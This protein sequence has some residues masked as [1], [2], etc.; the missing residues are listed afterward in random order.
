MKIGVVT[1]CKS[2][3]YGAMLQAR[4]LN[5]LLSSWGHEIVF[6]WH[7]R[8][9]AERF[10][11]WRCFTIRSAHNYLK[12]LKLRLSRW[13]SDYIS[14][15]ADALRMSERCDTEDQLAAA[16]KDCDMVI[17]GSDQIWNPRWV[18]PKYVKTVFLAFAPKG[19]RKISY[20][21]SFSEPKWD[22][23][24]RRSAGNL[25][26]Q[27]DAISVREAS[28]VGIVKDLC[29]RIACVVADPTFL[30]DVAYYDRLIANKCVKRDPGE[31]VFRYMI[32]GWREEEDG[33]AMIDSCRNVFGDVRVIEEFDDW[34]GVKRRVSVEKWLSRIKF[35]KFILTNSFHGVV[36]SLIFKRPFA[37]FMLG[38]EK[39][40]MN[41]R[42]LSLLQ[43]VG[44]SNR[45]CS[46]CAYGKDLEQ[47]LNE[48]IN[49]GD[50]EKR[51]GLFKSKS[52]NF[53]R[54]EVE[55]GYCENHLKDNQN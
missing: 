33:L 42:I 13:C 28:G 10:P 41:E 16:A 12:I 35:S 26:G 3:N 19:C 36:I 47:I 52:I 55:A 8:A 38:A 1:F 44:L 45:I 18:V 46:G 17:A 5:D 9:V 40:G 21:A 11:L 23:W 15:F 29:G 50:V 49:W 27:F 25:L 48:P 4:A 51:I 39:A 34:F 6:I 2:Q 37:A 14:C 53:L 24:E 7:S 20:A 31:Y 30:Q 22:I 43:E 54:K 32:N